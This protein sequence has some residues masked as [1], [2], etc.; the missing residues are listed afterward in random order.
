VGRGAPGSGYGRLLR[1][2][3]GLP[4]GLSVLRAVLAGPTSAPRCQNS[5]GIGDQRGRE[6]HGSPPYAVQAVASWEYM[7]GGAAR[8]VKFPGSPTGSGRGRVMSLV[9][10]ESVVPSHISR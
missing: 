9:K 10:L 4:V 5:A 8:W 7:W 1:E 3:M 2:L 6:G